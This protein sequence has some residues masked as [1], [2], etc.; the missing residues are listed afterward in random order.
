MAKNM[1]D[2]KYANRRGSVRK[3]YLIE[4]TNI[5][6]KI[7]PMVDKVFPSKMNSLKQCIG[8]FINSR[9]DFLYDYAPMNRILF[10]KKDED[11]YFRSTTLVYNNINNE[12]Q[13]LYYAT[14]DE[15]QACKDP[16]SVSMMMVLR[17]ILINKPKDEKMLELCYM[18]LAFSGKFYASAYYKWFPH[19]LPKREVMDYVVSYMLSNKYDLIKYGSVWGAI[20]SLTS[21]WMDAYTEELKGE[22]TDERIVYMMHQLYSRIYGFLRNIAKPYFE[23]YEKKLYINKE[24]DNYDQDNYRLAPN[25]ATI[26]ANITEKAMNYINQTQI[27]LAWCY[28]VSGSGVDPYEIKTILETVLNDNSKLDDLRFVINVMVVDFMR[29]YPDEKIIVPN[30][31]FIAQSMSL[32]PNT[33]DKDILKQKSIITEWLNTSTKYRNIK[34]QASR[35][36]YFKAM[37]GY[38]ALAVN[39]SGKE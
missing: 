6:D 23:A 17:W 30:A 26:A 29:K 15:L 3:E 14:K 1:V 2:P 33:K 16:Y 13:Q 38:I 22:V 19:Y 7:Y 27:N 4:D 34:T 21:M 28:H 36:N 20:R 35:N 24:S 8:R 10:T 18:Y 25:N 31:K 37:L 39:E 5:I 32:K 9:A 12:I 11:D